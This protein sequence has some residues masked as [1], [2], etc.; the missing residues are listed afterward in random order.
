MEVVTHSSRCNLKL[1][2]LVMQYIGSVYE[3]TAGGGCG[4]G[5]VQSTEAWAKFKSVKIAFYCLFANQSTLWPPKVVFWNVINNQPRLMYTRALV[6]IICACIA[7]V[8]RDWS[9]VCDVTPLV[10]TAASTLFLV[11][12]QL[13]LNMSKDLPKRYSGVLIYGMECSC[14]QL[15]KQL[16][17]FTSSGTL[18]WS[19]L[20]Q[21]DERRWPW[22][23]IHK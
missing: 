10:D 14:D 18:A 22:R 6:M 1:C 20:K 21:N 16:W 23:S 11:F 7:Y 12:V 9:P 15:I 2:V 17:P 8:N 4:R 19:S 5:P 3:T 13:Y